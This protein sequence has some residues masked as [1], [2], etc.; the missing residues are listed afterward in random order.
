MRDKESSTTE[1]TKRIVRI[2]FDGFYESASS[3]YIDDVAEALF[4]INDQGEVNWD[5]SLKAI[6][7]F[8]WGAANKWYA[9]EY[10][11]CF[12]Q[13][14]DIVLEFE[15][16]DSPMFYNYS[17]DRIFVSI[18]I[19]EL[20]DLF[21]DTPSEML[22]EFAKD[23]FTSRSGF[24]SHYDPNWRQWGDLIDWDHNQLYC[25]LLAYLDE[26]Y[27]FDL[28]DFVEEIGGGSQENPAELEN[29]LT[30]YPEHES[31]ELNRLLKIASYLRWRN[32]RKHY[33]PA[34]KE[35]YR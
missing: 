16:L 35:L 31:E 19:S 11:Y 4:Q 6:D 13:V 8:K 28:A 23:M 18:E 32:E 1:D 27:G 9:K 22:T 12:G 30:G 7:H 17:T 3:Q 29:A 33:T 5:L 10:A 2:P 14:H 34:E 21:I 26:E 15:S 25:L 24:A 20:E